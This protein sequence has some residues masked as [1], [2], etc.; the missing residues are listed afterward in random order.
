MLELI[1]GVIILGKL[2][3]K[4]DSKAKQ[5]VEEASESLGNVVAIAEV[6]PNYEFEDEIADNKQEGECEVL[7]YLENHFCLK[8]KRFFL[9]K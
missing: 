9:F 6:R 3:S 8:I 7:D 2:S 4:V 1:I 5:R